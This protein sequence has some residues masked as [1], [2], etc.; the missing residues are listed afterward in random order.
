MAAN[1]AP[2]SATTQIS[3]NAADHFKV[4]EV[5]PHGKHYECNYCSDTFKGTGTRCYIHL[6]GDGKGVA[7]C[8]EVPDAVLNK[9]K[10]AKAA[11][12]AENERKRKIEEQ[13]AQRKRDRRGSSVWH[14]L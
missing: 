12:S 8:L 6:T 11:K 7:H 13:E 10:A 5:L 3:E 2:S 4:L 14:G 1:P 9:V